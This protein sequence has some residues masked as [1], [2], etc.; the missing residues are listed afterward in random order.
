MRRYTIPLTLAAAAL[1][2]TGC[3]A[4]HDPA[5]TATVTVTASPSAEPTTPTPEPT[6]TAEA[7]TVE[8]A[9]PAETEA[10]AAPAPTEAPAAAAP[11][12]LV[13]S[14]GMQSDDYII[15]MNHDVPAGEAQSAASDLLAAK[16]AELRGTPQA[17]GID[18]VAV[19]GPKNELLAMEQVTPHPQC[20]GC[21]IPPSTPAP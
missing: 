18:L 21:T 7:Q 16:L 17:E 3:G 2:M 10:P 14:E 19:Y 20:A 4:Q 9:P 12:D 15:Y 6:E 11:A 1:T 5:P 8:T 13:S